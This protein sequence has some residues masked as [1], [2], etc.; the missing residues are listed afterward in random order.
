MVT[1]WITSPR[2][3]VYEVLFTFTNGGGWSSQASATII[4]VITAWSSLL[5]YDSSVHMTE[6]AKDASRTIPYSLLTAFGTNAILAF[7]ACITMI[8]CAGNLEKDLANPNLIPFVIVF[9]NS[10]KSKAATVIMIVPILLTVWSALISQVATAS[11]QL[12]SFARDGGI[13]FAKHLAP[14]SAS[15]VLY[16]S[17][18]L[19]QETLI[20]AY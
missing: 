5:G 18:I 11:R 4:G 9:Q 3:H 6:N 15:D 17:N 2:G 16:A 14:V 20:P 13:P 1:L 12:W 8:F 10:T 19:G 7:V